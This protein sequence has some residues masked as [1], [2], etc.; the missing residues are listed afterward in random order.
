MI[1]ICCI[2]G[3]KN[4]VHAKDMCNKH[5]RR[6]LKTGVTT[7]EREREYGFNNSQHYMYSA[8]VMMKDRCANPNNPAYQYYGARGISVCERWKNSFQA[9]L[10]DVGERPEHCTLDRIDTNDNYCPENCRWATDTEQARNRRLRRTST[11]GYS[12]I[13]FDKKAGKYK[14]RRQNYNTGQREYLGVVETLDEAKKLYDT[15]RSQLVISNKGENNPMAKLTDAQW[16][17]IFDEV[18]TKKLSQA[19]IAEKYNVSPASVSKRY[20]K[21]KDK[22]SQCN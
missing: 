13:V 19:K 8:W 6:L 17:A 3:C 20:R 4:K 10:A 7:L 9:Y 12:G 15:P 1:K 16:E 14:V 21:H 11:T 18:Q 5:Y 22:S 2:D